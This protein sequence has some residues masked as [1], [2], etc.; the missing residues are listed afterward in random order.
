METRD[1]TTLPLPVEVELVGGD[2]NAF[3]I[4]GAV[5]KAMKREG[6]GHLVD[7]FT[8]EATEGDYDHLLVTALNWVEVS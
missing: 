6:Y 7:E 1:G 5:A 8:A 2:G 4:M 3:A